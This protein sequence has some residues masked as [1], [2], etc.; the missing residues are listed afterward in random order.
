MRPQEPA[1]LALLGTALILVRFVKDSARRTG[2]SGV[3]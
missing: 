2:V 1:S 3:G